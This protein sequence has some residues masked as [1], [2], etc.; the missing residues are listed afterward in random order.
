ME[1]AASAPTTTVSRKAH[2]DVISSTAAPARQPTRTA[3]DC[4]DRRRLVGWPAGVSDA[5]RR[6]GLHPGVCRK[7]AGWPVQGDRADPRPCFARRDAA[8][9]RWPG[10]LP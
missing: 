3:A 7:W 8:G 10:G 6:P 1:L 5:A 2:G 9:Y 4:I